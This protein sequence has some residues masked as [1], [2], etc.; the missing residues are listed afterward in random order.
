MSANCFSFS[1]DPYLDKKPYLDHD[2]I[3][4]EWDVKPYTLTPTFYLDSALN[5]TGGFRPPDLLGYSPRNEIF[6]AST[7]CT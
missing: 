3:C 7:I 4:V 1:L 5:S 2:A 6:V